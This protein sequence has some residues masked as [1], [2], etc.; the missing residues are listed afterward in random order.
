MNWLRSAVSMAL[1]C[2]LFF[3]KATPRTAM[4]TAIEDAKGAIEE[5]KGTEKELAQL[6]RVG[7]HYGVVVSTD[8][9]PATAQSDLATAISNARSEIEKVNY[10]QCPVL[11][12]ECNVLEMLVGGYPEGKTMEEKHDYFLLLKA[13]IRRGTALLDVHLRQLMSDLGVKVNGVVEPR[14]EDYPN[15][16]APSFKDVREIR[17]EIRESCSLLWHEM[18]RYADTRGWDI[19]AFSNEGV[20]GW[21]TAYRCYV[22]ARGLG[23]PVVGGVAN[24][25][26]AFERFM[27]HEKASRLEQERKEAEPAM[28]VAHGAAVAEEEDERKRPAENCDDILARRE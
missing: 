20:E 17:K 27:N 23:G 4:A 1:M 11:L 3:T 12:E 7:G 6:V 21:K 19:G 14:P 2:K 25:G 26:I 5:C 15:D 10:R 28:G 8:F 18:K 13:S 24:F 9:Q 16:F 22:Q